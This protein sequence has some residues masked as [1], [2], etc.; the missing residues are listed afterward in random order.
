MLLATGLGTALWGLKGVPTLSPPTRL[1]LS[2][3]TACSSS[4]K[5]TDPRGSYRRPHRVLWALHPGGQ[6]VST[7]LGTSCHNPQVP[8]TL[9]PPALQVLTEAT[10]H[11]PANKNRG[12][13][14]EL[15]AGAQNT[16]R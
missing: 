14:S 9:D 15:S 1:F 2:P 6:R 11:P 5:Q 13:E 7:H 12:R 10:H 8:V 4:E 3:P 16:V